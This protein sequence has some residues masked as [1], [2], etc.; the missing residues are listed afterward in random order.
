MLWAKPAR[1]GCDVSE[2][3][4]GKFAIVTG[5]TRGIGAAIVRR[6]LAEGYDVATCG[7]TPPHQPIVV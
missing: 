3:G 7:R 5:G 6:L 4:R 1:K 2:T